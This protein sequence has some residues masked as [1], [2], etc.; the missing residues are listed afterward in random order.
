VPFVDVLIPVCNERLDIIQDT[1]RAALRVDYPPHRFR[2][3]VSDDGASAELRAWVESLSQGQGQPE[4][5]NYPKLYYTSRVKQGARAAGYKAGNLNH[6]LEVVRRLPGGAADYVAGLDADMVP[7]RKW[8]RSV[9]A[10]IVRDDMLGLVCPAQLMYNTPHNDPLYQTSAMNWYCMDIVR[11][12]GGCGWNLG[13]GWIV[14]REAV[15]DIGGFPTD[16][17]IEDVCSSMMMQACGWRT[18]YIPQG[19]QYGLV[20]ETYLGHVKQFTRWV[21]TYLLLIPLTPLPGASWLTAR[22]STSAAAKWP[23]ASEGTYPKPG[24]AACP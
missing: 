12:L 19:L 7:E 24:P 9:A 21:S 15:E 6:A 5:M 18:I 3:V 11:D 1:V 16:C 14:R 13:S 8:L 20:P 2:V 17:L 22:R 10:H 4:N 23:S